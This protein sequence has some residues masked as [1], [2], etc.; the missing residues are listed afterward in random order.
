MRKGT[1]TLRHPKQNCTLRTSR[2]P[3]A[4]LHLLELVRHAAPDR[5]LRVS[6]A[7]DTGHKASTLCPVS[8]HCTSNLCL[9]Q[10]CNASCIA[11]C[12]LLEEE[13]L[14]VCRVVSILRTVWPEYHGS[15]G[16]DCPSGWKSGINSRAKAREISC[17][18]SHRAVAA[19]KLRAAS[20]AG[21]PAPHQ[22]ASAP[23]P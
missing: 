1:A 17:D 7:A 14:G 5:P 11:S 12:R 4:G 22:E 13:K 19:Q 6:S 3:C 2:V 10:R 18:P 21:A 23:A 16:M 8:T 20:A 15:A 9:E